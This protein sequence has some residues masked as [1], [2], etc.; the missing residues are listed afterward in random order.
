MNLGSLNLVFYFIIGYFFYLSRLGNIFSPFLR[1]VFNFLYRNV[2]YFLNRNLFLN[3]V[4]YSSGYIFFLVFYS[5][6]VYYNFFFR[7]NFSDYSLLRYNLFSS[8]GYFFSSNSFNFFIFDV[9]SFNRE[10]FYSRF[11]FN[12]SVGRLSYSGGNYLGLY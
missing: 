12:R 7:N 10:V 8:Y 1:N 4:I 9:F 3:S 5:L 6:V 2:F 11:S